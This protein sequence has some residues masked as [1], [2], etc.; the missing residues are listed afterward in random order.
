MDGPNLVIVCCDDLGYG[1]LGC[2]GAEE[3]STP[4]VDRLAAEGVR[5]TDWHSNAP[6]CSP[7]RASLLTGRYPRRAGVP[8]NVPSG[9]PETDP[10]T[11][12]P[13][14]ERTL[15]DDLSAAGYRTG[16]FGKWHLGMSEDDGPLAHG[17]DEFFGFRSGCVDYYSHLFVWGQGNGVPPY[18]DLW[19]GREEVWNDGEYLT[20][21][22]TERAVEFIERN[23]GEDPFF[24]YVPY[25]APH[26]PMHAPEEY[27]DRFP[28][29]PPERRATAAMIAAVDDGVGEIT[30]TLDRTGVREDTIVLFTSDHG[31]S[32]EVRNHLDGS[33]TAFTG[34]QTGPF[35]GA[36]FSL[37]EGGI[38][39]PAI[40]S[41]P[42]VLPAG[43]VCDDLLVSMDVLPTVLDLCDV[44]DTGDRVTDGECQAATLV[45]ESSSPHEEVF[46]ELNEQRAV[47]RGDWKLVMNATEPGGSP[48]PVHLADLDSDPTEQTNLAEE[49]PETVA[50]LE[51]AIGR[52]DES[53]SD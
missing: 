34:G 22:I 45:G 35:R 42:D 41:Y 3:V 18:H 27:F 30:D 21:L 9:R 17:F 47:R 49:R 31:P 20:D 51:A 4:N 5:C 2:Y 52:W 13:P 43:T 32:R 26:Y 50:A 40:V 23:A 6:V 12:L 15:A 29:L 28:D 39:V 19:D 36:K 48:D 7:S 10:E 33:E 1:D 53:V 16:A 25:N 8:G 38:R 11:G 46:W 24:A 37:F 14:D 44:G